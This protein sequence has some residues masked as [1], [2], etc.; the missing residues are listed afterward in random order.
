VKLVGLALALLLVAQ[1]TIAA[2]ITEIQYVMGTYLRMTVDHD[3]EAVARRAMRRCAAGVRHLEEVFSRFDSRSELS[4]LN[5]LPVADG[6]VTVSA[7]MAAL[8]D[9]ALALRDTTDG[10]FDIGVGALTQLW[11]TVD[12]WPAQSDIERARRGLG[13]DALVLAGTTLVR[14]ADVRID[15]DG[16]AKG[17][18]VDQCVA[19]LRD[20]G[21]SRAF[22]NFGE[23]SLYALG[24]PLGEASWP[25]LVRAL[26]PESALGV[27]HLRDQAASVSAVL[28]RERIV[29]GRRIGHIVNPTTG[30]PMT[31]PALSLVVAHSATDAEAFSKAVLIRGGRPPSCGVRPPRQCGAAVGAILVD[32]GGLHRFG[33]VPFSPRADGSPLPASA[34]VLQ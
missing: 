29:A 5:A 26:D 16:V 11:R 8:L 7:D 24:A 19:A 25:V 31:R 12:R 30:L 15:V 18:A 32:A 34:G 3:D 20:A 14:H 21:V 33:H 10:A 23:S 28:G 13:P 4:R 22:V 9:R 6:P 27:L 1:R 2:P 17:W